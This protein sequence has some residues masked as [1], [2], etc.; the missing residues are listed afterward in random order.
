MAHWLCR[1]RNA[2]APPE[3]RKGVNRRE[4][5]IKSINESTKGRISYCSFYRLKI[6]YYYGS[7]K[8]HIIW[9]FIEIIRIN[10]M[11]NARI[12]CYAPVYLVVSLVS[13]VDSSA[14]D[15]I[16]PFMTERE[17]SLCGQSSAIASLWW[18]P[19]QRLSSQALR[20]CFAP[21]RLRRLIRNTFHRLA[22]SLQ[23]DNKNLELVVSLAQLPSSHSGCLRRE[24]IFS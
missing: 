6:S 7:I 15:F 2:L 9:L 18:I 12:Y 1:L 10:L 5:P 19:F 16:R 20:F 23:H 24:H 3:A 14:F 8:L 22:P 4:V 13:A 21:G 11:S 17:L